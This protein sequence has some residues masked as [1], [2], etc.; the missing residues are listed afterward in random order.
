MRPLSLPTRWF[1]A[2]LPVIFLSLLAASSSGGIIFFPVSPAQTAVGTGPTT[3]SFGSIN[4]G[5]GTYVLNGVNVPAFAIQ[6]G[7]PFF[8]T[9]EGS[10][11]TLD[12]AQVG[13]A[14]ARFAL[15]DTIDGASTFGPSGQGGFWG[16]GDGYLGLRINDGPNVYYGWA[17]LSNSPGTDP[18]TATITGFAFENTPGVAILAGNTGAVVPEPGT[19]AA[20]V[21][22][23]GGAIFLRRRKARRGT[24]V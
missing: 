14:A 1:A 5:A 11:G 16:A 12:I 19:W 17:G 6:F 18:K 4:L 2:L 22:V 3:I 20:A 8:W 10:F 7:N 21:L 9:A 24:A 15:N 23:A 13:S